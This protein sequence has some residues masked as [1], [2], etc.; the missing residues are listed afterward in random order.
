MIVVVVARDPNFRKVTRG[1]ARGITRGESTKGSAGIRK[2]VTSRT[3]TMG[4]NKR[5]PSIT[6]MHPSIIEHTPNPQA[7][8]QLGCGNSFVIALVP[9]HSLAGF[10][11]RQVVVIPKAGSLAD[12]KIEA[13]GSADAVQPYFPLRS[14]GRVVRVG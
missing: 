7:A 8:H 3:E 1:V 4:H 2:R 10:A 9:I 14:A 6:R 12:H 13:K 11:N 5:S